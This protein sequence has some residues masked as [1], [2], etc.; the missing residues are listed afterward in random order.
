VNQLR[1]VAISPGDGRDLAPWIRALGD[2]GLP[3]LLVREPQLPPRELRRLVKL[4]Q[5]H[6]ETVVVHQRNSWI[7]GDLPIH[8]TG[9]GQ[10]GDWNGHCQVGVSCHS[11][12]EVEAALKDGASYVFYSPVWTP[13]SKPG[14]TRQP[15]GLEAY[16]R[17][18]VGRPVLALGGT[19]A[20]RFRLLLTSGGWGAAV[21]G[22]LFGQSS[23][24]AAAQ[25]LGDYGVAIPK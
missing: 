15:I 19:N 18:A 14:D 9:G 8:L 17:L 7:F 4:A 5:S 2:A 12:A 24:D 20:E 13:T 23:P 10:P 25:R 1:F 16:L 22:D 11:E 6:I 3:A 21:I